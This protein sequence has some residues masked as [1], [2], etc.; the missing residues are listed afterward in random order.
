MTTPTQDRAALVA[1]VARLRELSTAVTQGREAVMREFTMRIPAEPARD[2]DLVL[3]D[4]AD[5]LAA[6]AAAPAGAPVQMC[7][8][9][10]DRFA[11]DDDSDE[12]TCGTCV[13][14]GSNP[15]PAGAPVGEPAC[16]GGMTCR[17]CPR[18]GN[19]TCPVEQNDPDGWND[20]DLCPIHGAKSQHAEPVGGPRMVNCI[21]CGRSPVYC[22]CL[23]DAG[24]P[25]PSEARYGDRAWLMQAVADE[26]AAGDP[27]CTTG[28]PTPQPSAPAA[29][30]PQTCTAKHGPERCE[31]PMGHDGPHQS[32]HECWTHANAAGL[33]EPLDVEQ[34]ALDM[35]WLI[36]SR[37]TAGLWTVKAL[38]DY[39]EV[40]LRRVQPAAVLPDLRLVLA[41]LEQAKAKAHNYN[42]W[43]LVA[44]TLPKLQRIIAQIAGEPE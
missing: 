16:E 44:E 19:C 18:C 7:G 38:A 4:A 11:A 36:D 15:Y 5:R 3:S 6:L 34:L 1:L 17:W 37:V 31:K 20:D 13:R 35:A 8:Q 43:L 39:L 30:L 23:D 42:A 24:E 14:A 33:P 32:G 26:A 41:D 10:G 12:A 27:D 25:E 40:A 22:A 21:V 29:V 9:C 2:A 28:Q